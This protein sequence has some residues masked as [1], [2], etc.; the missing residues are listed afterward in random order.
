M[1]K[2]QDPAEKLAEATAEAREVL[3]EVRGALRDL[4]AAR[5]D[6]ETL[7]SRLGHEIVVKA[8]EEDLQPR[9][10]QIRDDLHKVTE[11]AHK[12]IQRSYDRIAMQA[13]ASTVVALNSALK[14]IGEDPDHYL[15]NR[16]DPVKVSWW[17]R[18]SR[19]TRCSGFSGD[20]GGVPVGAAGG[21]LRAGVRGGVDVGVRAVV[22]IPADRAGERRGVLRDL[23]VAAR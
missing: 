14:I 13:S 17:R 7:V 5:K 15:I 10:N 20:P 3:R 6:A 12:G 11:A 4:A 22:A 2:Q 19:S 16:A 18:P 9:I 21:G 8:T 23:V 1:S